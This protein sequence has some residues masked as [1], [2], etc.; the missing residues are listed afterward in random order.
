MKGFIHNLYTRLGNTSYWSA[1]TNLHNSQITSL[2]KPFPACCVFTSRS[3]ASATN[4][5]DSS[6]SVLTPLP[7]GWY[8]SQVNWSVLV[9][10]TRHGPHRN[11]PVFNRTLFLRAHSLPRVRVYGA[12]AQKR[13]LFAASPLSNGSIRHNIKRTSWHMVLL[14]NL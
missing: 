9:I 6:V 10:T 13:S 1:T 8:Y 12:V 4:S 2:N 14:I 11:H 7:A 5:D 3:L